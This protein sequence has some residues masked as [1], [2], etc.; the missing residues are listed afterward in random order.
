MDMKGS[1]TEKNLMAAFAGESQARNRYTFYA[2]AA[3]DEGYVQIAKILLGDRRERKVT[4]LRLLEPVGGGHAGVQ[5][6]L[7]GGTGAQDRGESQGCRRRRVAG[8]GHSVSGVRGGGGRRG[9]QEGGSDI[10]KALDGGEVSRTPVSQATRL[11][12]GRPG[13][14]AVRATLWKCNEC[15]YVHEGTGSHPRSVRCVGKP[16]SYFEVYCDTY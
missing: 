12:R 2:K 16:H 7:S 11:G 6:C 5:G 9:L 15:G 14:Q 1:R 10:S 13:V 8:M 4:C 3:E